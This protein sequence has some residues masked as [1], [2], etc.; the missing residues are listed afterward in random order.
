M[1]KH[2]RWIVIVVI[3]V[4][5]FSFLISPKNIQNDDFQPIT[6]VNTPH[7]SNGGD[8]PITISNDSDLAM[9]SSSGDGNSWETAY[10]IENLNIYTDNVSVALLIGNT[11]KY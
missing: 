8:S 3:T 7:S 11:T 9:M 6:M 1:K 5:I 10:M 4:T 2:S